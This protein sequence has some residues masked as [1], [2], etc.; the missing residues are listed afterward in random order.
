MDGKI[1]DFLF[2]FSTYRLF[3]IRN[4]ILKMKS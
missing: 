3:L 4:E 2:D 1:L